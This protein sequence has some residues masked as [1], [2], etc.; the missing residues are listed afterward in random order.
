MKLS[1]L[2]SKFI[3]GETYCFKNK[4]ET[5]ASRVSSNLVLSRYFTILKPDG[6]N[7]FGN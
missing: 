1:A 4:L 3:N 7:P 5:T 6:G 2:R